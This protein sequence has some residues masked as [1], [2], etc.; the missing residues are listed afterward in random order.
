MEKEEKN[1][2]EYWFAKKNELYFRQ[3]DGSKVINIV[4]K[5]NFIV[6]DDEHIA[7]IHQLLSG[8]SKGERYSPKDPAIEFEILEKANETFTYA[9]K[10]E[11]DVLQIECDVYKIRFTK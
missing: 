9:I 8:P 5:F 10:V 7:C 4:K 6:L 3:N 1:F 2:V 11:D